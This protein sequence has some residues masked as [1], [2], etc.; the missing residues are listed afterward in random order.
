MERA[1]RI[2]V[3]LAL[4]AA[5]LVATS[6]HKGLAYDEVDNLA[7]GHRFLT[8]GPSAPMNGQRMPVLALNALGCVYEGC[9]AKVLAADEGGRLLVRAPTMLFALALGA[10]VHAWARALFGPA[11]GLLALLLYVTN[12]NVLAHGKQV[13]SDVQTAFFTVL[14]L[15]LLWQSV[16]SRSRGRLVGSGLALAGALAS[17]LTSV[18]LVPIALAMIAAAALSPLAGGGTRRDW[19]WAARWSAGLLATALLALNAIYGFDGTFEPARAWPWQSRA[20][21]PLAAAP[22]PLLLPR[23]FALGLDYSSLLQENPAVGRGFNYVLG[24]LSRDGRWDAFPLM[25]ALKNPLALFAL[26]AIACVVRPRVEPRVLVLLVAPAAG[27]IAFF[28][29]AVAPQLGIRYILPAIPFLVVLAGAAARARDRWRVAVSILAAWHVA[30]TLS[31]HPHPMAYFSE[32][33]GPRV[34]AYRYLADSNLDWEDHSHFIAEYQRRHPQRT[35]VVE[36]AEPQAGLLLVGA[37]QLVG[38][39]DP[40]RFRWLRENF[41]P[42]GHVAYSHLLFEVRPEDLARISIVPASPTSTR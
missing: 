22:V 40:E 29:L 5:L 33:I 21:Q 24:E 2:A 9:R 34:N 10:L 32:L 36:P 6:L 20:F 18:L 8:M 11:G 19:R 25:L 14:A 31:Y 35:L 3:P 38:I 39:F 13:T 30:S 12:P 17:K 28:S 4:L 42:V 23:T 1:S 41:T 27:V 16:R 7:Y 26:I 15:Y 37:N